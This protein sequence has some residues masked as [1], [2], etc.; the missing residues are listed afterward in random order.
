MTPTQLSIESIQRVR[1]P[2]L[3]REKLLAL[4]KRG[5][6]TPIDALREVGCFSL[7]QRCGT[8]RGEGVKVLDKWVKLE[9]GKKIKAYTVESAT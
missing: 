4:L 1:S 8:F 7:S 6:V 5:W 2:D 9:S 3:M